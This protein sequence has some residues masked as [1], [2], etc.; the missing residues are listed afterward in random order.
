MLFFGKGLMH[1][2]V[3][4]TCLCPVL[5][6]QILNVPCKSPEGVEDRSVSGAAAEL[7]VECGLYVG[8]AGVGILGPET[9]WKERKY[10]REAATRK[11]RPRF[12][13][14]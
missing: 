1:D 14:V 11:K 5:L 2:N 13:I 7:A 4:G 9:A 10:K 6:S 8:L 12:Q 3:L